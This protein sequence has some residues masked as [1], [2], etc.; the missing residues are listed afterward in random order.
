MI[1]FFCALNGAGKNLNVSG[2]TIRQNEG[3]FFIIKKGCFLE[4][5]KED[6]FRAEDISSF[7]EGFLKGLRETAAKTVHSTLNN[8]GR[9]VMTGKQIEGELTGADAGWR[10]HVKA[11]RRKM[12]EQYRMFRM[13]TEETAE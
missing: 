13:F 5:L 6:V 3:C 10:E 2:E 8:Y 9:A 4:K 12:E 7:E 1:I 11:M